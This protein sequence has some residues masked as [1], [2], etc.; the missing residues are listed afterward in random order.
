[1]AIPE[2]QLDTWSAQGA[3]QQSKTTYAIVKGVLESTSAPYSAR[4]R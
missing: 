2:S 3:V 4:S 1:M